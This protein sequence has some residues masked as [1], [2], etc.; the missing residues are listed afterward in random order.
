MIKYHVVSLS[1]ASS[2]FTPREATTAKETQRQLL[3][4]VA[5][6]SREC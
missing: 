6:Y 3:Q 5:H 1:M 2:G 4:Q